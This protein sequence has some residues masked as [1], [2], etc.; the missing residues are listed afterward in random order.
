[1]IAEITLSHLLRL[2]TEQ[3]PPVRQEQPLISQSRGRAFEMWKQM[4]QAG[5]YFIARSL[6]RQCM[7]PER[8]QPMMSLGHHSEDVTDHHDTSWK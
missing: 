4:M 8:A 7:S 5:E 6:L 3:D 1:V 2:A